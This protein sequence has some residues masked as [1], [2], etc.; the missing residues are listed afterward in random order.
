MSE[1]LMATITVKRTTRERFKRLCLKVETYKFLNR[2]LNTLE[3]GFDNVP[4][5]LRKRQLEV[6]Q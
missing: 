5:L 1:K 3:V 6:K 2:L 4:E